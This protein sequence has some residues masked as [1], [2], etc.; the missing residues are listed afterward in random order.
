MKRID[1][2][3]SGMKHTEMKRDNREEVSCV[4]VI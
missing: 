2:N 1:V 3:G 4:E